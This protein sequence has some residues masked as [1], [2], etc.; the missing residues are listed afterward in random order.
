MAYSVECSFHSISTVRIKLSI[1]LMIESESIRLES[2]RV[3]IGLH[4]LA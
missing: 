2:N 4:A 1:V 3:H